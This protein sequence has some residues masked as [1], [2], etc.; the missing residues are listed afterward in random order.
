V[1]KRDCVVHMPLLL[2]SQCLGYCSFAFTTDGACVLCILS[3]KPCFGK[4]AE[5]KCPTED[6]GAGGG[7]RASSVA[8]PAAAP[9][10]PA[11]GA[12]RFRCGRAWHPRPS[13]VW[14]VRVVPHRTRKHP[15]R[16]GP[17]VDK[18]GVM[19][20][21]ARRLRP[22]PPQ[23]GR[24]ESPVARRL[25][26]GEAPDKPAIVAYQPFVVMPQRSPHRQRRDSPTRGGAARYEL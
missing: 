21:R 17:Y 26:K 14:H 13:T 4:V 22:A 16:G 6:G 25:A 3:F 15:V 2:Q 11:K 5:K 18:F 23:R 12:P 8:T 1:P 9:W 7:W 19:T 24:D 10:P 20:T